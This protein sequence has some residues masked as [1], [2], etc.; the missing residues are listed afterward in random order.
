VRKKVF[1]WSEVH[2]SEVTSY[3]IH[4]LGI[5][6]AQALVWREVARFINIRKFLH[7]PV[8]SVCTSF[9]MLDSCNIKSLAPHAAFAALKK[10]FLESSD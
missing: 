10:V 1:N 4:T 7:C 9:F 5:Q 6:T 3:K 8:H 2:L